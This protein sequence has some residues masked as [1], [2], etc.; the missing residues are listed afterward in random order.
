MADKYGLNLCGD[1]VVMY[2]KGERIF[3]ADESK[4]ED[5]IFYKDLGTQTLVI[6]GGTVEADISVDKKKIAVIPKVTLNRY[7]CDKVNNGINI[8]LYDNYTNKVIENVGFDACQEY[9]KIR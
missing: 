5:Y 8:L 2:D 9:R 6:E 7:G 4:T 1:A 3:C